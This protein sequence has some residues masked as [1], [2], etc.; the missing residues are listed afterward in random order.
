MCPI[1][2]E[3]HNVTRADYEIR[4]YVSQR[5][6]ETFG[7]PVSLVPAIGSADNPAP[8]PRPAPQPNGL[9]IVSLWWVFP[10]LLAV[11]GIAYFVNHCCRLPFIFNLYIIGVTLIAAV[12]GTRHAVL[13]S[14]ISPFL[15]NFFIVPPVLTFTAPSS[16][17][18]VA[19]I[20]TMIMALLVPY[21]I[22]NAGTIQAFL[23]S[24][25]VERAQ[26]ISALRRRFIW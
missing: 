2:E 21:L 18:Y 15:H 24:A 25:S 22:K 5:H 3:I 12:L 1:G 11:T 8:L 9:H 26:K 6:N 19:G 20:T 23:G 4:R 16:R 10:P 7:P 13:G 14:L 17:E